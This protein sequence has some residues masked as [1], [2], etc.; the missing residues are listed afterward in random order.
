MYK[1]AVEYTGMVSVLWPI[2]HNDI[3]ESI[4]FTAYYSIA[5]TGR[6]QAPT[7]ADGDGVAEYLYR[8]PLLTGG[9]PNQGKIGESSCG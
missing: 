6:K 2:S 7:R 5:V 3:P 4:Y 8:Y 9:D 1:K